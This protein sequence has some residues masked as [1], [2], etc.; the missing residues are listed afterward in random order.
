MWVSRVASGR[1]RRSWHVRYA[2]NSDPIGA[3]QR[4]VAMCHL[5]TRAPQQTTRASV[6]L[7]DHVIGTQENRRRQLDAKRLSGLEV[8]NHIEFVGLLDRKISG[9]GSLQNFGDV[10]GAVTIHRNGVGAIGHESP[11]LH[12][13]TE[14]EHTGQA[15]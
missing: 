7:F 8:E 3:S 11:D 14:D 4:S 6:S 9:L 2:S 13:A 15:V 5:R 10:S 12:I 1:S